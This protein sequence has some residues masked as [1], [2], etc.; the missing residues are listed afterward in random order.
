MEAGTHLEAALAAPRTVESRVADE[1][2]R[3]GRA[4]RGSGRIRVAFC[5]DNMGVGGT[6]LNALRTAERLDRARFEV[7]VVCLQSDGPLLARYHERGI[8]VLRLPIGHLYGIRALRQAR[9]LRRF[10]LEERIDIVHC[11]DVYDNIFSV[12]CARSARVPVVIASRRWWDEVPRRVLRLLNQHAYRL[13]DRVIANSLTVAQLLIAREG[14]LAERVSVVPN[15]VGEEAF[16]PVSDGARRA[17]LAAFDVPPHALVAGCV[18]GVRPVKDHASLIRALAVLHP[19]WPSLHLVLVGDGEARPALQALVA[20]LELGD[21]VHFAGGQP[22]V[23]NPHALFDVSVLCSLSEAFPNSI[24]EA[25]AA[26]TAVVATRVGGV[27]DAVADGVTGLLVPPRAPEPLAAA[28]EAL[29]RDPV[30]RERMGRAGRQRAY[31]EFH[32][33]RVIP[34]LEALYECLLEAR[35]R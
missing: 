24:V 8:R 32:E 22:N 30:W 16:A 35:V 14:V 7:V 28:I 1:A 17:R 15:F 34:R 27:G 29:L 20:Q 25:M 18:A 31:D 19:G 21:V 4:S 11:H 3:E 5:I 26:G 13:A 6:E 33:S 12:A 9:R 23:P 10:F 2:W